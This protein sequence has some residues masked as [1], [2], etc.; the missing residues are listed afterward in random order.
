M[1][2]LNKN[3]K[4]ITIEQNGEYIVRV[5]EIINHRRNLKEFSFVKSGNKFVLTKECKRNFFKEIINANIFLVIF[6]SILTVPVLFVE[7]MKNVL[8]GVV[9]MFLSLVSISVIIES[10]HYRK[11]LKHLKNNA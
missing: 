11:C 9:F 5:W 6:I 2:F 8:P 1:V 7:D 3:N 10:Y 4:P